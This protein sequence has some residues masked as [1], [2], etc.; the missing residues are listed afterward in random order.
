MSDNSFIDSN[1]LIYAMAGEDVKQ[2]V[3]RNL[4]DRERHNI[5]NQVVSEVLFNLIKKAGYSGDELESVIHELYS[6]FFVKSLDQQD[7][8]EAANIRKR[9]DFSFWDS[10]IVATA[11]HINCNTLYSEDM[12]HGMVVDSSLTIINPFVSE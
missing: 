10:L 2:S 3:A 11:L 5:S 6:A 1:I 8:L 9:Y 7:F 12:Q 4:I